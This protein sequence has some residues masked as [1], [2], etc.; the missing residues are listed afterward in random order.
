MSKTLRVASWMVVLSLSVPAWAEAQKNTGSSSG[1]SGNSGSS[2][3]SGGSRSSGSSGS[4]SSGGG[5]RGGDNGS[6]ANAPAPPPAPRMM[7]TQPP[8]ASRSKESAPARLGTSSVVSPS[9][10]SGARSRGAQPPSGYAVARSIY[11]GGVYIPYPVYVPYYPYYPWYGYGWGFGYAGYAS[12]FYG[13]PYWGWGWGWGGCACGY[14]SSYY[15]S[16]EPEAEAEPVD[17]PI[18]GSLRIRANEARARVYVDGVLVGVVDDFDGLSDHLELEK[19]RHTI[20]LQADGFRTV[21]QE[22]VVKAGLTQTLR[23]T[24]K[25]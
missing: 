18:V 12:W 7:T 6:S 24:L 20:S 23:I 22:V 3:S 4:V 14:G 25:R 2:G 15:S 21:T 17:A 10:G 13:A 1:N 5:S 11:G 9:T 8:H 19:G 16:P